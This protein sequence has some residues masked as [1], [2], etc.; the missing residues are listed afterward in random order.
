MGLE[1]N[2]TILREEH[3]QAC[4]S[5]LQSPKPGNVGPCRALLEGSLPQVHPNALTGTTAQTKTKHYQALDTLRGLACLLVAGY[6]VTGMSWSMGGHVLLDFFLVLSGFVLAHSYLYRDKPLSKYE[7]IVRRIARLWPL[8]VFTLL[9]TWFVVFY[10]LKGKSPF[11]EP[12]NTWTTLI[13]NLLMSHNIGLPPNGPTFW[14]WNP[15][16]WSIAVE[17]WVNIFFIFFI[18]RTT[19]T[20]V[21]LLLSL[22]CLYPIYEQAGTLGTYNENFYGYL[23]SGLL[24][25]FVSFHLGIIAYRIFKKGREK[26]GS[27]EVATVMEVACILG[28]AFFLFAKYLGVVKLELL[29]PF[30]FMLMVPVYAW[31]RGALTRFLGRYSYLGVISF[32]I[33][34]NHIAMQIFFNDPIMT[35]WMVPDSFTGLTRENWIMAWILLGTVVLSHFTYQYV[36]R[37]AQRLMLR[38][39]LPGKPKPVQAK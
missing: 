31:E 28:F 14:S 26:Q 34:L 12:F 11:F 20:W 2:L 33:Y 24:R 7:F 23:N 10:G 32:S 38:T 8:H 15:P 19:P 21:L 36:E 22:V 13:Q 35:S 16:S 30:F 3:F 39:L 5:S 1:T 18:V 9:F 4:V 6:H 29:A 27:V 37:P 25:G 17:F